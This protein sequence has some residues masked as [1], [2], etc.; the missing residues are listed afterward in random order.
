MNKDEIPIEKW[1]RVGFRLEDFDENRREL[2]VDAF[3]FIYKKVKDKKHKLH[4]DNDVFGTILFLII[5]RI[6]NKIDITEDDMIKIIES[7]SPQ[8]HTRM[9][10]MASEFNY[11]GTVDYDAEFIREYVENYVLY[12]IT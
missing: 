10:E 7:V 8:Y 9:K 5:A 1:E 4:G 11:F 3:E 2:I 12:K 6:I